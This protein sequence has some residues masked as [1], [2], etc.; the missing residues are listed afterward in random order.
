MFSHLGV[1][2]ELLLLYI[3]LIVA[4]IVNIHCYNLLPGCPVLIAS[5]MNVWTLAVK[6]LVI[7]ET[8][9]E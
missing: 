6:G 4:D 7:L 8:D 9:L 1:C 3:V 2:V 5:C